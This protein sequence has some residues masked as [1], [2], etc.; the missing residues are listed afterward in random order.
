MK[1]TKI[2]TSLYRGVNNSETL[3]WNALFISNW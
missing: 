1:L 2:L 3:D